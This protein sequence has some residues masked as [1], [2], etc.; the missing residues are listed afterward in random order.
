VRREGSYSP[1]ALFRS[2]QNGAKRIVK[3]DFAGL[4]RPEKS[5]R[6]LVKNPGSNFRTPDLIFKKA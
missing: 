3:R 6:F 2:G 1:K 4:T 5:L